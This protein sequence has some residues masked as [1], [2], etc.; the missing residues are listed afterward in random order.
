[1]LINEIKLQGSK[2]KK[3]GLLFSPK[4]RKRLENSWV[5]N[6]NEIIKNIIHRNLLSHLY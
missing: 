5:E 2:L 3:L 6:K 4:K 1:M